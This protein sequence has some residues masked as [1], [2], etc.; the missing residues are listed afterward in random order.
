LLTKTLN[1]SMFML[2]GLFSRFS[3]NPFH[4]LMRKMFSLITFTVY[5]R[6]LD[7]KTNKGM[8]LF[9]SI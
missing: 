3:S 9:P 8:L 6:Y 2:S 5:R 7:I 1:S 4:H